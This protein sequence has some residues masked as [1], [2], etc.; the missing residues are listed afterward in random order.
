[1]IYL[2]IETLAIV[3]LNQF[4]EKRNGSHSM[5]CCLYGT[6]QSPGKYSTCLLTINFP[7]SCV[8]MLAMLK[9]DLT[10]VG[11]YCH[12]EWVSNYRKDYGN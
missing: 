12:F 9:Q 11:F 8:S 3:Y 5:T 6:K 2:R 4:S 1:M 10:V 7:C